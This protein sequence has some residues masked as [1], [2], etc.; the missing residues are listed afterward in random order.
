MPRYERLESLVSLV[1]DLRKPGRGVSIDDMRERYEVSRR[2]AERMRATVARLFPELDF[3]LGSDNKRY[4]RL[5][6]K[7]FDALSLVVW[8]PS[9]IDALERAV[10]QAQQTRS[11]DANALA[12]IAAKLQVVVERFGAAD[13]AARHNGMTRRD[14]ND[15]RSSVLS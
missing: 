2:T 12:S 15:K 4:W 1:I 11:P 5:P 6:Q 14:G 13:R 3:E 9:E 10:I 8:T 7:S